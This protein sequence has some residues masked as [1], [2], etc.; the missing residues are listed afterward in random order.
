MSNSMFFLFI[1][2]FYFIGYVSAAISLSSKDETV[3]VSFP[4]PLPLGKGLLSLDFTGELN[5][6]L[7]GFYRCKYTGDG[8]KERFSAV[9]HFEVINYTFM[10]VC[11][12]L[13]L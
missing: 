6:R 11:Q 5:D 13:F 4:S 7:K 9:T 3:T 1:L 10:Y 2:F 8:G 12:K